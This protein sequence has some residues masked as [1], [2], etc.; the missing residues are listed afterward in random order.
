MADAAAACGACA[1]NRACTLNGAFYATFENVAPTGKRLVLALDISGSMSWGNVGGIMGLT[2]R[3]ASAAL[4][5]VT[6]NAEQE[7]HVV[8]FSHQLM[9]L[10]LKPDMF[11]GASREV[12]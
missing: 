8:G 6:L 4:A 7:A 11:S 10:K 3:I 12:P 1:C 2:P 5:L 9:P